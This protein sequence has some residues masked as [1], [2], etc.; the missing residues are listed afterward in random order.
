MYRDHIPQVKVKVGISACLLGEPVRYDGGHKRSAF[1]ADMLAQ[2]VEYVPLCPEAAIG[3]GIPRPTI[4]L[5]QHDENIIAKSADGR[6]VTNELRQYGEEQAKN[7]TEISGYIFCAKSPSC[8]MERVKVYKGAS[9][10][11]EGI[12]VGVYTEQFQKHQPLLPLEENG[13]LN[14]VLLRENFVTRIYAYAH[15]Q[16]I[17]KSGLTAAKLL[18][19]HSVYK[20]L[21]MAHS[22]S[23]YKELGALLADLKGN[24]ESKAECYIYAFMKALSKPV[25]RKAH[26]NVL[27][28]LQ[29]YFKTK[30]NSA[31]RQEFAKV[32][33]EYRLGHLPLL[34]PLTLIRHFLAAYPDEYV[35]KQRYLHPFPDELNLRYG[36]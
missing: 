4:R 26:A 15:W 33:E 29:G 6:D 25:S 35:A 3:L 23:A 14:D 32:I 18:E 24:V 28:H 11:S 9:K 19:F 1:C 17:E 27:M 34:A 30:L 13:R 7:Q 16:S 2:F 8:G 10:M 20:Y 36:I 31:Q 5:E 12:G 22:I 21:V